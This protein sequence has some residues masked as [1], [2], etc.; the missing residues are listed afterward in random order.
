SP[1]NFRLSADG[2]AVQFAFGR[3]ELALGEFDATRAEENALRV[4]TQ[5][6]TRFSPPLKRS[7]AWRLAYTPKQSDLTINDQ[8][9][10]LER[11]ETVLTHAVDEQG[12]L[13]CIGTTWAIRCFDQDRREIAHR[14]LSSQVYQ[15]G[16]SSNSD[17][18]VAALS[19][20]TIRWYEPTTLKPRLALFPHANT[21]DWIAWVPAGLYAS[22]LLG[23][24]FIGWHV[25]GGPVQ[26]PDFFRAVQFE[27]TL[28][29]KG[30]AAEALVS[31]SF[32]VPALRDIAPSRV[33]VLV[34][35]AVNDGE[36]VA[37]LNV[38]AERLS[39]P[40][41]E[42]AV[43]VN[44]IPV[45]DSKIRRLQQEAAES[46]SEQIVI[47]LY[48]PDN[49]IRV[50]VFNGVSMGLAESYVPGPVEARA[51][52][53]GD[54]YLLAIGVNTFE[55]E[56]WGDLE[57]AVNDAKR[58]VNYFSEGNGRDLFKT[59]N[60]R[61]LVD[62]LTRPTKSNVLDA[63]RFVQSATADDTVIIALAS[64]GLSDV[65]GN[66]YFVPIDGETKDGI[67]VRE[68]RSD[69]ASLISWQTFFD[70]LR[71][72]AGKR[73]LFVDTC[74]SSD[75]EGSFDI[76]SL[77]KRSTSSKFA[78]LTASQGTEESQ[79][80]VAPGVSF[81]DPGKDGQGLFTFA[82]LKALQSNAD[83]NADGYTALGEV[84]DYAYPFVQENRDKRIGPQTPGL[85]APNVLRDQIILAQ[86]AAQPSHAEPAKSISRPDATEGELL[87][88]EEIYRGLTTRSFSVTPKIILN[89]EFEFDSDVLTPT[90]KRQLDELGRAM[91]SPRLKRRRFELSGHTD[92]VGTAEYNRDLSLRRANSARTYLVANHA[93]PIEQVETFG[94]GFDQLLNESDPSADEN[95]RVEVRNVGRFTE[96]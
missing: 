37:T 21:K 44:D 80:Y 53:K 57:F 26:E 92:V 6:S 82:V 41:T 29:R 91:R 24:E 19:D 32:V 35:K 83:T 38:S 51:A 17:W 3:D 68:G 74:E 14:R 36:H 65:K 54:L 73:L 34:E 56:R 94:F 45:T 20:G 33:K 96:R 48:A 16:L 95:R 69:I 59:V 89:I 70:A 42:F 47:P 25:N 8:P 10:P 86:A 52:P 63:L 40:Q 66:Y 28:Y 5:R 61:I 60:H 2:K 12:N 67:R 50:E 11:L 13:A 90:A 39:A 18:L 27:R 62:D 23:D 88:A 93:V 49:A 55:D 9:I 76:Y 4:V 46:F 79:E 72:T 87:S 64:H 43:Y 31:D 75:M 58:M 71:V 84:F 81:L 30:L 7:A 1:G 15:L 77:G 78:L 22:S 85:I